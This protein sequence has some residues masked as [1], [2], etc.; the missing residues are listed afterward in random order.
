MR[1]AL[2]RLSTL[3]VVLLLGASGGLRAEGYLGSGASEAQIKRALLNTRT[4][5]RQQP[6]AQGVSRAKRVSDAKGSAPRVAAHAG[7]AGAVA[8]V[9]EAPIGSTG[10]AEAG[11]ASFEIFFDLSS[12]NLRSDA[13]PVLDRLGTV[14]GSDDLKDFRFVVEGHTD[15]TGSEAHN[16]ELSANRA[17]TVR[18]YLV[19]KHGIDPARLEPV[20]R[21]EGEL[22]DPDHPA[23]G[24]N[25][26][27]RFVDPDAGT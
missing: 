25:R 11:P 9:G 24:K 14:L 26:R 1:I 2:T 21:G 13:L 18:D 27:V 4:L 3:V 15:A 5:K 6:A 7:R 8:A 12:A 22:Y 17:K 20:G 23:S 10:S 19:E 16:L